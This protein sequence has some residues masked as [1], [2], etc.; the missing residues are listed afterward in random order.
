MRGELSLNGKWGLTYAEGAM[1]VQPEHFLGTHLEG[2]RLMEA[3]VPAPIHKVLMD[4]GIVDDPNFGLNSLKARWVEEQFWIYRHKFNAPPEA[5][6]KPAWL[7]FDRIE[8]S[9]VLYLNGEEVGRHANAH[10]PARFNVTG[11]LK[12]GENLIVMQVTTGMHEAGDKPGK[13][14]FCHPIDMLTKRPWHRKPQYQ[15][16]WDWNPR[17]WNGRGFRVWT[18][19][20]YM[21]C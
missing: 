9:A 13:D 7:V 18:R 15:C 19:P 10:R 16:G 20:A 14:Y 5:T 8:T 21:P 3:T 4:A 1:Q 12:G 17:S 2:R 11:K 6:D